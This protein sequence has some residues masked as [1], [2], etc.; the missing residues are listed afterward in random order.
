MAKRMNNLEAPG[1]GQY[2]PRGQGLVDGNRLHSLVGME[3]QLAHHLPE[4]T[5]RAPHGP[6]RTSALGHG[7]VEPVHVS[8]RTRFPHYRSGAADMIRVAV[9]ENEVLELIR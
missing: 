7:D 6:K 5:G 9:S 3:K 4:E 1:D 2:F 8:R